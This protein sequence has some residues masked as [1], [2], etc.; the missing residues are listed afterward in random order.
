FFVAVTTS[1]TGLL[2]RVERGFLTGATAAALVMGLL[3]ATRMS[4]GIAVSADELSDAAF[5]VPI[6]P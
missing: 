5:D 4:K 6:E 3:L 2:P 1:Q